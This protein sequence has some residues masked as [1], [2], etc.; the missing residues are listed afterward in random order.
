MIPKWG[1]VLRPIDQCGR[2]TTADNKC[3]K[4]EIVPERTEIN[5]VDAGSWPNHDQVMVHGDFPD[6]EHI[7]GLINGEGKIK[8]TGIKE[9][10]TETGSD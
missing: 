7:P 8:V 3:R 4:I 1:L 9:V 6:L 5:T 10:K 2:V